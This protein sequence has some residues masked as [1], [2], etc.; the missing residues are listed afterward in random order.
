MTTFLIIVGAVTVSLA[1]GYG[2]LRLCAW[3]DGRPW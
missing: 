2:L 1:F 3:C